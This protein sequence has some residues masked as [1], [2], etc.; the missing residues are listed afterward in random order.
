MQLWWCRGAK[1]RS[2]SR[3]A[4]AATNDD[5]LLPLEAEEQGSHDAECEAAAAVS[6]NLDINHLEVNDLPLIASAAAS[7]G[8]A[9][10]AYQRQLQ[11]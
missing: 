9:R 10:F 7:F 5:L 8:N 11:Y 4:T 2:I 6:A 3:L 1:R